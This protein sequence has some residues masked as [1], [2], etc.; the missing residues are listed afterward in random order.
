MTVYRDPSEP[1]A[2]EIEIAGR[3]NSIL[4]DRAYPNG[5]KRVW[6]LVVAEECYP[7]KN[8]FSAYDILSPKGL[9]L[10]P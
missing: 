6:G 9:G 5:V 1:G 8:L 10:T 7:L 3:L 2:D 4:G